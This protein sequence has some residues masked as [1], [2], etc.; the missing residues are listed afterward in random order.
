MQITSFKYNEFRNVSS[1]WIC[2][3]VEIEWGIL[4]KNRKIMGKL[5]ISGV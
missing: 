4:G 2:I 3:S 1:I 5:R